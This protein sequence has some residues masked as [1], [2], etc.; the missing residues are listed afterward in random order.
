MLEDMS[1]ARPLTLAILGCGSR[2]RGYARLAA[3]Q[4][5][6]YRV[7]AV[8]DSLVERATALDREL[9][10]GLAVHG[11]DGAFLAA[12]R[13]ADVC[14][15]ATQDAQHLDH[16]RR[17]MDAGYDLLLEKPVA[18]NIADVLALDGHARRLGRKVMICHVLRFSPLWSAVRTLVDAGEIGEVVTIEQREGVGDFHHAHSFV[19]GHWAVAAQ[20]TP[21][22]IAK[23]CHDLDLISWFAGARC[24]GVSSFGSLTWFRPERA[25]AGAPARCS[26]G[27]PHSATC[28]YDAQRYAREQRGWLANVAPGLNP[29]DRPAMERWL[30]ESPWG[31]CAWRCGNDAVDHQVVAMEFAGGITATLTMTAF[32][33]GRQMVICGTRGRLRAGDILTRAAG[34]DILVERHD[35]AVTRHQVGNGH[36]GHGGADGGLVSA[37]AGEMAGPVAAMRSGLATAV[38]SH[39]IGFAA[40]QS[41]RTGGQRIDPAA[42]RGT[43]AAVG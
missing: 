17:A 32:D 22:I 26:D 4:P 9:G 33:E 28:R 2:G 8:A 24:T 39:L 34:C 42:L 40:E 38:E 5:W 13:L 25:P 21:M 18:A 37:L 19:R 16:A 43:A 20:S 27:C 7:V 10:G 30:R 3:A 14:V 12:G 23:C 11:S 1:D 29:D 6:R 36:G 35:G 31:R 41:R 15:V